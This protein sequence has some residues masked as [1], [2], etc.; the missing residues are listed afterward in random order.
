L[1]IL[2]VPGLWWASPAALV[3]ALFNHLYIWVH[4]YATER[5]DMRRIYG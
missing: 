5:P 3:V 1:L 2:W 4:Y